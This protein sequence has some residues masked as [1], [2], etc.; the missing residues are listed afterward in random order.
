LPGRGGFPVV[1][2]GFTALA[3]LTKI[4]RHVG[5]ACIGCEKAREVQVLKT[6]EHAEHN[7]LPLNPADFQPIVLAGIG[8]RFPTPSDVSI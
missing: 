1:C 8:D 5:L 4:E 2:A 3:K 7:D 6:A